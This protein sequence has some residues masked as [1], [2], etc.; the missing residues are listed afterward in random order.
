VWTEWRRGV[1]QARLSSVLKSVRGLIERL[2]SADQSDS[3]LHEVVERVQISATAIRLSLAIGLPN[4]AATDIISLTKD[5]PMQIRRRGIEMRMVL[6]GETGAVR[7]DRALLKAVGRARRWRHQI[8][9]GQRSSIAE[10]A[11]NERIAPRYI[12]DLMPLAF[13]SPKIVQ[14]MSKAGS[15]PICPSSAL[16]DESSSHSSGLSSRKYSVLAT[17]SDTTL[18]FCRSIGR[19]DQL[20]RSPETGAPFAANPWF[21]R[22]L[23]S[24]DQRKI[25]VDG[26]FPDDSPTI[27]EI[28]RLWC[29]PSRI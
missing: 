23:R 26:P 8:E 18:G 9:S 22:G 20:N 21:R 25:A 29:G 5:F 15:R 10:I 7:L 27:P 28:Q 16:R 17:R 3:A 1:D 12:R 19:W 14:A 2:Q 24:L 11:R 6:H 13:L 4:G